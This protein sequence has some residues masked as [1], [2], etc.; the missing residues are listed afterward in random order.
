MHTFRVRAELG[1]EG[2]EA[3]ILWE[4]GC[5]GILQ[6]GDD[7]VA[8]FDERTDLP[9][10]GTWETPEDIDYVARYY[11]DLAAVQAGSLTVAPTHETVSLTS[12]G[13]VLWVDPG[14]AFGSGH[15]RTTHSV[16]L[17]LEEMDLDGKRVLDVGA[18]SGILALAADLLGADTVLGLDNDPQTVPVAQANAR[19]NRSR[20]RFIHGTLT[21][22]S[23]PDPFNTG[24]TGTEPPEAPAVQTGGTW[25]VVTANLYAELHVALAHAYRAQ[26]VP[27]GILLA[28]GVLDVQAPRVREALQEHFQVTD[29]VS[30]GEWT[31]FRARAV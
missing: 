26:L 3:G 20:A 9:L 22:E 18:G 13:K 15:H 28:A 7:L 16:L 11:R 12:G 25:D 27:G 23:V 17:W 30:D 19:L 10:E 21:G 24:T 14:M 8:W 31:S 5:S 2:P 6:E 4:Y 1:L 29:E